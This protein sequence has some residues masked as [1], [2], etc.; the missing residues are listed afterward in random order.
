MMEFFNL[1]LL[2]FDEIYLQDFSSRE[3]K[4][5]SMKPT[6]YQ[7]DTNPS[8]H[9]NYSKQKTVEF[10]APPGTRQIWLKLTIDI[11][12]LGEFKFPPGVTNI[13]FGYIPGEV[14][15]KE[16]EF[17]AWTPSIKAYIDTSL[18]HGDD[19]VRADN[20]TTNDLFE[21]I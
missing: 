13:E 20:K 7:Y 3:S 18:E 8:G 1:R 5:G 15:P 10:D 2:D 9:S 14:L 21:K 16:N 17:V 19:V 12:K 6:D 11:E 4:H